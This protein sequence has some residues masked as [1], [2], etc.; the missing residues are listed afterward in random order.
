MV[1]LF[2]KALRKYRIDADINQKQMA[3]DLDVTSAFLSAVEMGKK[4]VPDKMLSRL[5]DFYELSE[6]LDFE[7]FESAKLS[8]SS[9]KIDLSSSSAIDR[10][11]AVIFSCGIKIIPNSEKKELIAKLRKSLD[12]AS[13]C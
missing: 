6:E 12:L 13:G 10:E 7:F 1:T 3:K 2:G 11:L 5:C 9:V 8:P 4:N